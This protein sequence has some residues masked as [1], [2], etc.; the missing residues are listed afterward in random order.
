[1][2]DVTDLQFKMMNDKY[3]ERLNALSEALEEI[4]LKMMNTE[5][6]DDKIEKFKTNI[7]EI[8]NYHDK[9]IEE[10]RYD[11]LNLIDK[12]TLYDNG[13]VHVRYKFEEV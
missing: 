13:E 9:T 8:V 11:L 6:K 2:G 4:E 12:I 10:K 1:M 3:S 7:K 5:D